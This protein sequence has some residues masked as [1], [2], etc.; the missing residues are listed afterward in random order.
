[1]V[2]CPNCGHT[3][4]SGQRF[5]GNCGND[6]Q[7]SAVPPSAPVSEQQPVPYAYS[8]AANYGYEPFSSDAPNPNKTRTVLLLAIAAVLIAICCACLVGVVIGD[9]LPDILK[10][11]GFGRT[12]TPTAPPRG[13]P[14]PST[15]LFFITN[16]L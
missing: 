12:P 4:P 13:T 7:A 15:L 2:N 3:V 10:T 9:S 8:Q 1:M 5:C 16:L 14:T 11:L 6:V